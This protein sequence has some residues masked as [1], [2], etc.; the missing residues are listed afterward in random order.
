MYMV[1]K[2]DSSTS[3]SKN[4]EDPTLLKAYKTLQILQD[5]KRKLKKMVNIHSICIG[6]RKIFTSPGSPI[7][8][9]PEKTP[10]PYS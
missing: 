3:T 5:F 4:K 8:D 9:K 2:D 10:N 7:T 6:P 1:Y